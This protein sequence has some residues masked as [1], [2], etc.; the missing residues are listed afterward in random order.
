LGTIH[1]AIEVILLNVQPK[2]QDWRMRGYGWFQRGSVYDRLINDLGS[3][4]VTSAARHLDGAGIPLKSRIE[5]GEAGKAILECAREE[6][7]NLIVLAQDRVGHVPDWLMRTARLS[8]GSIT[9]FVVHF[10]RVPVVVVP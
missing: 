6:D 5:L 10:A 2:P 7:C 1:G 9:S 3:R 8:I 4:I